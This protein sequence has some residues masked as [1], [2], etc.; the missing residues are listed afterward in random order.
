MRVSGKNFRFFCNIY[1]VNFIKPGNGRT[2]IP[3]CVGYNY[4]GERLKY[5]PDDRFV[6]NECEPIFEEWPISGEDISA[7]RNFSDLP[8]E[9]QDF[10][11]RIEDN[12]LVP[13]HILSVGPET[14]QIITSSFAA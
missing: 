11:K 14:D 6:M 5:Y 7:I 4:H 2:E 13:W 1:R 9:T 10:V 3:V 8:E 12:L